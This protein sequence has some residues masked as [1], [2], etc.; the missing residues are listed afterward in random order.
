[1][2]IKTVI[3]K[4]QDGRKVFRVGKDGKGYYAERRGDLMDFPITIVLES[5]ERIKIPGNRRG[6]SE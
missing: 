1:M 4:D 3:I 2:S 6:S 5:G